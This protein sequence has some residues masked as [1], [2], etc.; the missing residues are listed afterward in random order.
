MWPAGR[1]ETRGRGDRKNSRLVV[2]KRK[3]IKGNK[4]QAEVVAEP[5]ENYDELSSS[6]VAT[7][8]KAPDI[9]E[10]ESD[11]EIEHG[12][13]EDKDGQDAGDD[14]RFIEFVEERSEPV[15]QTDIIQRLAIGYMIYKKFGAPENHQEWRDKK[16]GP[17]I[18]KAFDLSYSARIDHILND[19]V[20]CKKAGIA[21]PGTRKFG[22][23]T[24]K[25]RTLAT[26]SIEAQIVADCLESGFSLPLAQWMVNQ[27]RKET[28][29]EFLTQSPIRHLMKRL[30]PSVRKVKKQAQ[31]STNQTSKWARARL[32][33]N[34]RFVIRF[35]K[36][37]EEEFEK[38]R[39]KNGGT[40][41][42]WFDPD[43]REPLKP[44]QVAWWDK[45]HRKCIIGEQRAGAT[46]YVRFPRTPEGK[47]DLEAGKYD[48]SEVAWVN[49]KYEKEVRLCLGCGIYEEAD[50]TTVG[51][52]AKPFCY[53]GKLLVSLKDDRKNVVIEIA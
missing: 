23:S 51:V 40:L 42:A 45:T 32:A 41:P 48:D 1:G 8:F 30:K 24:G 47:L 28:G 16:I 38:I 17:Q 33:F 44:Q 25:Q 22:P 29:E 9:V 52:C 21:Y 10:D 35:G 31:G 15:F 5:N 7:E 13:E 43:K 14:N 20:A 39:Q 19:V 27:H 3:G 2:K 6:E 18:R 53:S 11:S 46:H 4:K 49:V 37:P 50:G 36:L 26:N 12:D 34:T